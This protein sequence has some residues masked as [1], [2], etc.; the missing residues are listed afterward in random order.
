MKQH[1]GKKDDCDI[2]AADF[3]NLIRADSRANYNMRLI[4]TVGRWTVEFQTYFYANINPEIELFSLWH[5]QELG[6]P[7]TAKSIF[8]S[9]MCETLNFMVKYI[10]DFKEV[11]TKLSRWQTK[12]W[13]LLG[14]RPG[15]SVDDEPK[16]EDYS[17][18]GS[19]GERESGDTK[20]CQG[21]P[22]FPFLQAT[23]AE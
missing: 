13:L 23:Q 15:C 14:L 22:T 11:S 21:S 7:T 5:A 17:C 3:R 2:Y 9:N 6:Y 19:L 10:Q 8:S 18:L 4:N 1:G 16:E 20:Y 12:H